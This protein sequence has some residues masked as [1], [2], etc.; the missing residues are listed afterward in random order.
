MTPSFV[1]PLARKAG[2]VVDS[3]RSIKSWVRGQLALPE[4]TVVSV[5]ELAC[6]VPGCPPKETVILVMQGTA[7]LQFSIHKALRDV[8]EEDVSTALLEAGAATVSIPIEN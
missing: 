2:S 6:H 4:D 1:N 8:A 5:S 7:T 3:V